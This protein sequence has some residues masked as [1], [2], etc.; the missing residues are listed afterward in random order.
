MTKQTKTNNL[1]YLID[2][3]SSKDSK[4]FVLSFKNEENRTSFSECYTPEVEIKDFNVLNVVVPIVVDVPIK[5]KEETLEKVEM[6]KNNNYAT[7][8]LYYYEHFS[9]YYKLIAIDLSKQIELESF[10]LKRQIHFITK[11]EKDNRTTTFFI[12]EKSEET[13]DSF[14]QNSL[15]SVSYKMEKQ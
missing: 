9:K 15:N 3:T 6:T 11:L 12:V 4:L 5:N 8:C 14:S 1:D 13:S 7:G 2:P 10:D